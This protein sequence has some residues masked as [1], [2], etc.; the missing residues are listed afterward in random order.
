MCVTWPLKSNKKAEKSK[1]FEM[2]D[3]AES[4][5][6]EAQECSVSALNPNPKL[7]PPFILLP[8]LTGAII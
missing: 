7:Q 5:M 1:N 3:A 6:G 8:F 4:C 2:S